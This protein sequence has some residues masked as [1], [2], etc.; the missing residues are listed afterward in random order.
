MERWKQI[1][2]K[3]LFPGPVV[4]FVSVPV[5]AGLLVYTFLVAGENNPI[6]Y[7]AYVF[8]AY[9]LVIL[10]TSISQLVRRGNQK[11]KQ[12]PYVSR[13]FGDIPFKTR[14]SLQVSLAINLVYAGI[15]I[16]SG[17]YYGSAWFASLA[18][19]YI[20]LSA[21][22]IML[23]R[24]ANRQGFGEDQIAEWRRYRLCGLCLT[25]MNIALTGV[26]ILVLHQDGGFAYAGILIYVMAMYAFFVTI[27]AV[28]NVVQYRKYNSPAMSAA[29]AISLV[30]ALV[31]MLSLE[32]GMLAQF[33]GDNGEQ[34]RQMMIGFTGGAVC[35]I[36]IAMG[37]YM[38]VRSTRRIKQLK[39]APAEDAGGERNTGHG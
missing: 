31:S 36:V 2:H 6:A 24:Y 5:A 32:I 3:L 29:R 8:S 12:N 15:N 11:I 10:C 4:V 26:V 28:I 21:M 33:G 38:M 18:A 17:I 16:V 20:L 23:A 13:Y 34:F 25:V 37:I 30:A 9:A 7:I 1:L 19:Y 14:V 39:N 35:A 27:K 22:R